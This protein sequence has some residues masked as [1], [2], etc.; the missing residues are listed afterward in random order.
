MGRATVALVAVALAPALG[1]A[2]PGDEEFDLQADL[3]TLDAAAIDGPLARVTGAVNGCY[4]QGVT[5]LWYL[6][7]R[8]EVKVRVRT[9]GGVKHVA[10]TAPLGN[11]AVEKCIV[12]V[13]S[14]LRF[15]RPRGGREAEFDY[16]WDFQTRT[17]ETMKMKR[18]DNHDVGR[19]FARHLRELG[20]CGGGR[21]LPRGLKV[22]FF[23]LP[24][25][26]VT[27]VG[28][29]ADEPLA[30]GWASCLVARVAGWRFEDPLGAIARATYE[31]PT[32]GRH[33]SFLP[34]RR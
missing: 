15:A 8:F 27:S 3:G 30:D 34:S 5:R 18:W 20:A 10:A 4:Q 7:G 32:A 16:G 23:V 12:G 19:L 28:V 29:G 9:D 26:K 2:R 1:A 11:Y 17:P 33:D 6:G 14:A 13:V 25:G 21:A 22:T 24:G 31:F